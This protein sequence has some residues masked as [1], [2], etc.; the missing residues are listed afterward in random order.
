MRRPTH[1]LVPVPRQMWIQQAFS[2]F[3]SVTSAPLSV[4]DLCVDLLLAVRLSPPAPV[5]FH[6]WGRGSI[7]ASSAGMPLP[8]PLPCLYQGVTSSR[9]PP[10]IPRVSRV[11]RALLTWLSTQYTLSKLI[12]KFSL[13]VFSILWPLQME[14][15]CMWKAVFL[16]ML[17]K[18]VLW[19]SAHCIAN[20]GLRPSDLF[21]TVYTS[22]HLK[23]L[24]NISIGNRSIKK[25]W[26][27]S[28][29]QLDF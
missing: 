1:N 24:K 28:E 3:T 27:C 11:H 12:R 16:D 18:V 8:F 26:F 13:Y 17:S 7:R 6:P 10:I 23:A 21:R 15:V 20:R 22:L 19:G 9:S 14:I 25:L 5:G 2:F 29:G 4:L